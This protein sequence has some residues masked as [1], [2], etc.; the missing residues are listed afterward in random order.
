[1]LGPDVRTGHDGRGAYFSVTWVRHR[2]STWFRLAALLR[3]RP[4]TRSLSPGP[5]DWRMSHTSETLFTGV[6]L[7]P[8]RR[9]SD[10]TRAGANPTRPVLRAPSSRG[11]ARARPRR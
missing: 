7:A 2:T 5:C 6:T 4:R 8:A 3:Y 9:M 10:R 1:M 11:S